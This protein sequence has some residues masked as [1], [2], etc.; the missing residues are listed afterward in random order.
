MAEF[1]FQSISGCNIDSVT[2]TKHGYLL[3]TSMRS[4]TTIIVTC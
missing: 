1:D 3:D 4:T 2:N